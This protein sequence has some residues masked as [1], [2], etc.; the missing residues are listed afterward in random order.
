MRRHKEQFTEMTTYHICTENLVYLSVSPSVT[1][2]QAC[3]AVYIV[4]LRLIWIESIVDL[5]QASVIYLE[6][7]RIRE[8]F[9]ESPEEVVAIK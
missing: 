1:N 9:G 4:L 5:G 3:M 6:A 2:R 8:S 7:P